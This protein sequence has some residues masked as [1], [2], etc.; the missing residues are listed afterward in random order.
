[1]A[2]VIRAKFLILLKAIRKF[3]VMSRI[4]L[5]GENSASV[6]AFLAHLHPPA[7]RRE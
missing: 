4:G 6:L 7:Y 1:L 2:E 3:P 5:F